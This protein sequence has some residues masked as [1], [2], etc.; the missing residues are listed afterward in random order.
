MTDKAITT[1]EQ[2]ALQA[3][4]LADMLTGIDIQQLDP[5]K[6]DR[7]LDVQMRILDK[8]AEQEFIRA[9]V[10]LQS[11]LRPIE[12]THVIAGKDGRARSRYASYEEIMAT[13]RP[14]L[15]AHG[16]SITRDHEIHD[17]QVSCRMTLMHA[18]GHSRTN[19]FTVRTAGGPPGTSAEQADG[20]AA[21]YAA[22][23][24]L[25]DALNL[26][27]IEPEGEDAKQMGA[28]ISAEQAKELRQRVRAAGI[29]EVKFLQY[30]QVPVAGAAS[31]EHYEQ[32][33]SGMYQRLDRLV[34]ERER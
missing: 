9:F 17:K 34:A 3:P 15:V 28:P 14:L 10:A 30:A 32:I 19:T 25:R 21:S 20:S 31:D 24:A 27:Y 7:L 6:L 29:D 26:V 33:L 23:Y 5:E 22:R 2:T 4:R 16:F 1:T 13:L 18:G 11:Q 8:Q 12:T